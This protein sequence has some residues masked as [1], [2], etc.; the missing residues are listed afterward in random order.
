MHPYTQ[1]L[2]SAVPIES[3][4]LAGKRAHRAR[5]RRPEPGEPTLR[6]PLPDAL[7]EGAGDLRERDGGILLIGGGVSSTLF[8]V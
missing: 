5:G 7:L 1:A 8:E 6:L 4:N 3:P 2:L